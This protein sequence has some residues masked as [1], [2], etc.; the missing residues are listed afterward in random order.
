MPKNID[1]E[2]IEAIVQAISQHPEG[3]G[4][5]DLLESA[6]L[7]LSKRTLQRRLSRLVTAGRL[8]TS[9]EARALR[10]LIAPV[11][12][13][14]HVISPATTVEFHAEVYVPLSREGQEIKNYVRQAPQLRKPVSYNT[15]F[16]EDYIPNETAYLPEGLRPIHCRG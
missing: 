8:T 9:G 2:E 6:G 5:E 14:M 10:Y 1:P 13:E 4:I 7:G 12:G 11:T 16:L 15:A 3:V